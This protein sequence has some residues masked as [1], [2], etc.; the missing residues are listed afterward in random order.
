MSEFIGALFNPAVPFIRYALLAG[1]LSSTAFGMVGSFVVVRRISYI[2]GAVSHAALAGLGASL[3]LKTVYSITWLSPLAGAALAALLSAWIIG[4]VNL[5]ASE[6]ED[7]IIGTIWAVGMAIGLLFIAKT[8]GYMD[9]M[10][11]LFGN[12]LL[13]GKADLLLITVL[14]LVVV[15][16]VVIFYPQLQAVCFDETYARTRG[17]PTGFF[18][19]LLVTLTA[20]TVVLMVS[21]V[22]IVMVIAML[23]IPAA[24]AGLFSG[25]LWVMML[26][27]S[28]IC[29]LTNVSGL[30]LSYSL[31]IPTGATTIL[32][33]GGL[34]SLALTGR[35]IFRRIRRKRPV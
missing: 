18:T 6:R 10:S 30:A 4:L 13:I 31:D 7:T 28:I 24:T 27:A 17:V 15:I 22:G 32:V 19:L 20:V 21:T 35:T 33:S 11:Y 5:Y 1:L 3:Y 12:I 14:N 16:L 23:T 8:P 9:P 34:Y 2:A 26:T 25:R 29:A